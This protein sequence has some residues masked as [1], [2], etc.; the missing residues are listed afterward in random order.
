[1]AAMMVHRAAVAAS[2]TKIATVGS[3]FENERGGLRLQR[4]ARWSGRAGE[5]LVRRTLR[6]VAAS[7]PSNDVVRGGAPLTR[8]DLVGYLAS[9]CKPKEKWRYRAFWVL[10]C[11][12]ISEV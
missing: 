12:W 9:G 7:P 3:A 8:K 4:C 2:P 10:Q 1:M 6:I 11:K 5:R